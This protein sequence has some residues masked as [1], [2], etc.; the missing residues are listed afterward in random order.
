MIDL[1]P[2]DRSLKLFLLKVEGSRMNCFRLDLIA[3]RMDFR[4][5]RGHEAPD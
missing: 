1:S 4:G 5:V 2:D 3:K